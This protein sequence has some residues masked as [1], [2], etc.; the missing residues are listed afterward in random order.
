[1][2]KYERN[3]KLLNLEN[4]VSRMGMYYM[5]DS[6]GKLFVASDYID[7]SVNCFSEDFKISQYNEH[8]IIGMRDDIIVGDLIM[9]N[10]AREYYRECLLRD[11]KSGTLDVSKL[12]YNSLRLFTEM[13]LFKYNIVDYKNLTNDI[14]VKSCSF[15]GNST[16]KYIELMKDCINK[17]LQSIN[18]FN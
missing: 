1:M 3:Y 8:Y 17:H 9:V 2:D 11:I 4:Y 5:F 15:D 16:T 6:D 13:S 12:E 14:I 10:S 7:T 18:D